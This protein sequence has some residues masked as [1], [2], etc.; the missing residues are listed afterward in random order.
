MNYKQKYLKYKQKYNYLKNINQFGGLKENTVHIYNGGS[1]SPVT[2]AH[3]QIC[4][5]TIE[6]LMVHF[7]DTTI[8]NIILHLV[9]ASDF[10]EKQSVKSEC[11]SFEDRKEMVEIMAEN[12]KE[13]IKFKDKPKPYKLEV[14]VDDIEQRIAHTD[15]LDGSGKNGYIGTYRYLNKFAEEYDCIPGNIY[16]LFGLDNANSLVTS[17]ANSIGSFKRWKNSLHL[18][19]KFKFLIY[20]R[21][22]SHINYLDLCCSFNNNLKL[23]N[24][25]PDGQEE[26]NFTHGNNGLEDIRSELDYF[27]KNSIEFM[28]NHFIEIKN[29]KGNESGDSIALAEISSSNIRKV[30]YK[31]DDFTIKESIIEENLS[32][33]DPKLIEMIKKLYKNGRVC[34]GEEKFD[35]IARSI[36]DDWKNK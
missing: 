17:I 25:N 13:N 7:I 23:F 27:L 8:D 14:I 15:K 29:S 11:I 22:G 18:V 21:S 19:S 24:S 31:Y 5:D 28:K 33:I 9:P 10:Y 26:L 34:E 12:I 2:I 20:P 36:P 1:F 35:I 30:L 6:F 32:N 4:I 3:Q 16:L